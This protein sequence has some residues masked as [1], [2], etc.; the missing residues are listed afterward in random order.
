MLDRW[1]RDPDL[2]LRRSALLALLGPLKE[3][4]GD[5]ARFSRYADPMLDETEFFVRKAIGW[6]LRETGK[7]RPEMVSE[8]LRARD[9]RVP[10]LV[11]REATK[12]LRW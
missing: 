4:G 8:W 9:D 12:Y 3:G 2:W 5:F 1:A 6:V 11:R 10:G 7:R